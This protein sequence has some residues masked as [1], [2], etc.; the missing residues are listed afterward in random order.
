MQCPSRTNNLTGNFQFLHIV[1]EKAHKQPFNRDCLSVICTVFYAYFYTAQ[2]KNIMHAFA[3]IIKIIRYCISTSTFPHIHRQQI[4]LPS[5]KKMK[6]VK[7]NKDKEENKAGRLARLQPVHN[8]KLKLFPHM[9][10]PN[11][12]SICFPI[13]LF[14]L[15]SQLR[16]T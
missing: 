14:M 12:I 8:L 9:V 16:L 11:H 2:L 4:I 3:L 7:M 6:D 10:T 15:T 1:L 5:K 13:T